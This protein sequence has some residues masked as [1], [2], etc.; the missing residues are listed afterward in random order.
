MY[1]K[2]KIA[3]ALSVALATGMLMTTS[4]SAQGGGLF[5]RGNAPE[6]TNGSFLGVQDRN[7]GS[8]VGNEPFGQ[9][10]SQVGNEP[11]GVPIGGGI[12]ILVVAGMGY[13]AIKSKRNQ[14]K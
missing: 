7:T 4:M 11:F 3:I 12:A 14:H 10:G 9:T 5:V 8:S 1:K 13:V 6:T 2:K